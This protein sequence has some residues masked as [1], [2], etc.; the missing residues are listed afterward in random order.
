MNN[1]TTE[2]QYLIQAFNQLS[3]DARKII[4][5]VLRLIHEAEVARNDL[6]RD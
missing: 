1:L 6:S 5:D 3:S 2:E 4:L